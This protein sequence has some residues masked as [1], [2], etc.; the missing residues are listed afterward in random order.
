MRE[1]PILQ[2]PSLLTWMHSLDSLQDLCLSLTQ[3]PIEKSSLT[4]TP[5]LRQISKAAVYVEIQ[6][7]HAKVSSD[8]RARTDAAFRSFIMTIK[9]HDLEIEA[10]TNKGRAVN[11]LQHSPSSVIDG[12]SDGEPDTKRIK[13][14]ESAYAWIANRQHK[15]TVLQDTL[16]KTLK[17]TEM[18]TINP[19]AT[20]CSLVNEP[21]CPKSLDSKWKNIISKQAVN[22]DAVLSGQLSTT[23]DNPKIENFRDLEITFGAVKPTKL[24]RMEGIGPLLGI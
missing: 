17:L 14:D 11:P 5:L 15:H 18:Y 7:K 13:V 23:H 24:S 2:P 6:S 21:D 4:A 3:E 20:K 16:A 22:L 19:K 10:A 8:D 1:P 12:Q 9:S